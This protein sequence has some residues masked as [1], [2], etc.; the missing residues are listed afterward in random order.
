MRYGKMLSMTTGRRGGSVGGSVTWRLK[1][2]RV[3]KRRRDYVLVSRW[4]EEMRRK[5]RISK[6]QYEKARKYIEGWLHDA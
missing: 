4:L 2:K 6:D 1:T 5:G 3:I